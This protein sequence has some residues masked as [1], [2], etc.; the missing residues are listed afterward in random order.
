MKACAEEMSELT[1]W[2]SEQFG[3]APKFCG[4]CCPGSDELLPT[5]QATEEADRHL[6]KLENDIVSAVLESAVIHLDNELEFQMTVGDVARYLSKTPAQISAAL[7]KLVAD[8]ML[9]IGEAPTNGEPIPAKLK[10]FPT[11]SSLRTVPA[12]A[13]LNADEMENELATLHASNENSLG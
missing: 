4:T 3:D 7:R 8:Q 13:Q 10:V 9:G 1:T 6:T 11:V 5:S 12:F 2:A